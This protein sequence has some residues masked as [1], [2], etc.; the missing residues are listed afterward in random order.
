L[1]V[2]IN[3]IRDLLEALKRE[4]ER[5]EDLIVKLED[6]ENVIATLMRENQELRDSIIQLESAPAHYNQNQNFNE[7]SGA[8]R[9]RAASGSS[10]HAKSPYLRGLNSTTGY[11]INNSFHEKDRNLSATNSSFKSQLPMPKIRGQSPKQQQQGQG[12]QGEDR[13]VGVENQNDISSYVPTNENLHMEHHYR[14]TTMFAR[15]IMYRR[16]NTQGKGGFSET[17]SEFHASFIDKNKNEKSFNDDLTQ[18]KISSINLDTYSQVT[19][20]VREDS[21][22]GFIQMIKDRTGKLKE[23]YERRRDMNSEGQIVLEDLQKSIQRRNSAKP[24]AVTPMDR[25]KGSMG[26]RDHSDTSVNFGKPPLKRD[27]VH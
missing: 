15:N 2:A 8:L 19:P 25:S 7:Q 4:R 9:T 20:K 12:Q 6:R 18:D 23:Q 1:V 26:G 3:Q 21:E 17:M 5:N 16:G 27:S 24:R 10:K 14:T 11:N 13:F 22:S